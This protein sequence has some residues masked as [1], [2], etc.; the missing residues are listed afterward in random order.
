MD[1]SNEYSTRWVEYEVGKEKLCFKLRYYPDEVRL[2]IQK[3][4][5]VKTATGKTEIDYDKFGIKALDHMLM[6][7]KGIE[8][9]GKALKC[10]RENKNK[11]LVHFPDITE[12]IATVSQIRQTFGPDVEEIVKNF[13]RPSNL[14]ENGIDPT[15]ETDPELIVESA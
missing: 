2:A 12:W 15:V 10:T 4:C 8:E 7:W 3:E 14:S 1:I 13:V 6:D 5:E 9:N 11:F